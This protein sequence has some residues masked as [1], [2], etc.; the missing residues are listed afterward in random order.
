MTAVELPASAEED[1][2][3]HGGSGAPSTR[4][5]RRETARRFR[6]RRAVAA[7]IV[8][9]LLAAAS[10]L[11]AIEIITRLVDE[12][13][14]LLPVDRLARWGRETR[15]DDAVT[16][17]VA[18]VAIVLGLLLLWL[19]FWPGRTRVVGLAT[20]RPGLV[21]A[22]SRG[23]LARIAAQAATTVDGVS[24]ARARARGRRHAVV[25]RVDT[26]LRDHGDL[27]GQVK[28]RV[29]ERIN[30]YLP[31]RAVPVRVDVRRRVG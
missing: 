1:A 7:S 13:N 5:A 2:P 6:P 24:G 4:V 30:G 19:A 17:V 11:L 21:L 8:A 27:A 20:G 9:A 29:S 18:G 12:S 22:M 31:L 23:G 26:P 14:G 10:T 3:E 16:F 15:W 28:R 25:V